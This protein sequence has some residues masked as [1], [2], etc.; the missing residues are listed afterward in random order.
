MSA[1]DGATARRAVIGMILGV[2]VVE[3]VLAAVAVFGA[4]IFWNDPSYQ[5]AG[6]GIDKAASETIILALGGYVLPTV[7]G[8]LLLVGGAAIIVSTANTFLMVPSTNLAR[9]VYQRF[10][11]PEA[12]E[13]KIILFQRVMI[14]VLAG[15][16]LVITLFFDSILAMALYAYTMV[17]A[18]VTPALLAAFLWRRATPAAGMAS[19]IAGIVSTIAFAVA[20]NLG[21][22][23]QVGFIDINADTGYDFIIYPAFIL[24]VLTLVG[25]SLL[26]KAP[27]ESKWRPFVADEAS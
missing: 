15:V 7:V 12:S 16:A 11:N 25:V 5:A 8:A 9:D 3:S 27:D 21:W 17:G 19:V 4:G 10:V 20:V 1:K 18:A 26:G 24:S 2:V 22:E 14:V 13:S 23:Y 6:G